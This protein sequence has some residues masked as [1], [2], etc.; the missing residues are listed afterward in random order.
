MTKPPKHPVNLSHNQSQSTH[1]VEGDVSGHS[2]PEKV[3]VQEDLSALRK[4]QQTPG[5]TTLSPREAEG[6]D[7]G[8]A[9]SQEAPE[10]MLDL[11]GKVPSAKRG[12]QGHPG[13]PSP[14]KT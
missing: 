1:Q 4:P 2:F 13:R 11:A 5:K 10:E 9:V 6:G 7:R 12:D 14:W 3:N 8:I